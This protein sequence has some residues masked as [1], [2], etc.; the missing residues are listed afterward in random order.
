MARNNNEDEFNSA[1]SP[2]DFSR[3]NQKQEKMREQ[4]EEQILFSRFQQIATQQLK[5][6]SGQ[7]QMGKE[8]QR[9]ISNMNGMGLKEGIVAGILS[10]VVLRRGPVYIG[11]M[12]R[13][14]T[15]GPSPPFSSHTTAAGEASVAPYRLSDPEKFTKS[16]SIN[17]FHRAA[18]QFPRPRSFLSRSIWFVFDTTLSLLIA[19]NVSMA[20][21]DTNIIRQQIV[22]LPL[23][24]GR[25]L[26][27]DVLCD[28]LVEELRKVQEEK[29]P[30]YER[31][32]NH[33]QGDNSTAAEYYMDSIVRFCENC[34]RRRFSEQRIR[35]ERGLGKMVPVEVSPVPRDGPR[36][37][38]T[39]HGEEIVVDKDGME[40]SFLEHFGSDETWA[41]DF[42]SDK[43][44]QD[45][46][47]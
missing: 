36:L 27:A 19:A 35:E 22:E 28:A 33:S 45:R 41:A 34:E 30:T 39:K 23:V 42:V 4:M 18:D 20:S 8:E 3:H 5:K 13:R 44:D 16:A 46:N 17:P 25:S 26:T 1:S 12:V 10:F 11:R 40:S 9:I 47:F 43:K 6:V 21:T 24:S 14:R 15:Q 7:V 37:V 31:L 38:V 29:D 2:R 32:Q